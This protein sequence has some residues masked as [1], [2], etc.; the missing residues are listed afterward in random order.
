[1]WEMVA[2][3]LD[4]LRRVRLAV[5]SLTRCDVMPIC[6]ALEC[7]SPP[8][9]LTHTCVQCMHEQQSLAGDRLATSA[10]RDSMHNATHISMAC[11]KLN[12]KI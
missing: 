8:M 10:P 5:L 1:M 4:L 6:S 2:I 7:S 3:T 11:K 12:V 9:D